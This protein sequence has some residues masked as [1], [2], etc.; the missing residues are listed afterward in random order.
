MH[1]TMCHILTVQ[2]PKFLHL[3]QISVN[4]YI[5][6]NFGYNAMTEVDTRLHIPCLK[7]N[8]SKISSEWENLAEWKGVAG[9]IMTITVGR[10]VN[11]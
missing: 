6:I 8:D 7:K 1:N 2:L 11:A 10:G 9:K 3:L 5:Y 4:M